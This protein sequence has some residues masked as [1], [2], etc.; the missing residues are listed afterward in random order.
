M[1]SKK[2]QKDG[3]YHSLVVPVLMDNVIL[4]S[5]NAISSNDGLLEHGMV[6]FMFLVMI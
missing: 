4:R 2:H 1:L 6:T 5:I 3:T